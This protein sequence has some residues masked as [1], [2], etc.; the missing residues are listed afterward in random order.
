MIKE[1]VKEY[2]NTDLS[3]DQVLYMLNGL[4]PEGGS[5]Y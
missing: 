1:T 5:L 2:F 4:N 3:D